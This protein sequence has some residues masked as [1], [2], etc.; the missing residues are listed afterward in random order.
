MGISADATPILTVN[1]SVSLE[2]HLAIVYIPHVGQQLSPELNLLTVSTFDTFVNINCTK[3]VPGVFDVI[4]E[5]CE[6]SS[7]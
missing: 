7:E 5:R 1:L 2:Q 3:P 6:V 4:S